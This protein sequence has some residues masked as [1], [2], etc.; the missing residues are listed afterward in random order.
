MGTGG[1]EL[2][3]GEESREGTGTRKQRKNC[4]KKGE[5][6]GMVEGKRKRRK[7]GQVNS[8]NYL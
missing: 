6:E 5:K 8:N 1:R 4:D 7:V 3:T 2:R